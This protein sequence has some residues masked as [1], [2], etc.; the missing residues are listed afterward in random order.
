MSKIVAIFSNGH[1]DVY[2]GTRNVKAAWAIIRKSDGVTLASGHSYDRRAAE[3]SARGNFRQCSQL[4]G[5][6]VPQGDAPKG[7][8]YSYLP[9][10]QYWNEYAQKH[11]FSSWKAGYAAMQADQAKA[12]Q[13]VI[14]EIIDLYGE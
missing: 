1:Q 2:K 4:A 3:A 10:R 7:K 5:A 14:I 11:G 9:A 13:N 12:L 8:N 6:T